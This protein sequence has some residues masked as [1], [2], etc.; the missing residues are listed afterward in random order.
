MG[1][2]VQCGRLPQRSEIHRPTHLQGGC[3]TALCPSVVLPHARDAAN[4]HSRERVALVARVLP[5]GRGMKEGVTSEVRDPSRG[6]CGD[7]EFR[8]A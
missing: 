6:L 1:G 2:A 5:V 4:G 8:L 3:C 7:F